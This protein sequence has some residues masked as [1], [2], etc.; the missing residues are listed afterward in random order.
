MEFK[1]DVDGSNDL[2]IENNNLVLVSDLEEVRMLVYERLRTF[3]GEWFLNLNIGVPYFQE[4]FKKGTNL[5]TVSARLKETIIDTPGVLQ[6]T[7]FNMDY[8]E[9]TRVLSVSFDTLCSDGVIS[10]TVQ[11]V[12]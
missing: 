12:G 3:L 1:L 10:E 11:L 7:W 9:T 8:E 2:V 6:L 5:L 4:I